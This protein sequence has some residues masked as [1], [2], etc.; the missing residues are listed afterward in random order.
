MK[1]QHL[2]LAA[3]AILATLCTGQPR[4]F[5]PRL[6]PNVA[7]GKRHFAHAARDWPAPTFKEP[8][9]G[10]KVNGK[11]TFPSYGDVSKKHRG[12]VMTIGEYDTE[13]CEGLLYFGDWFKQLRQLEEK[14]GVRADTVGISRTTAR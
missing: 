1:E 4:E 11:C 2:A 9:Q 13:T 14:S 8:I 7:A 6:P 12:F 5:V 3:L 10:V